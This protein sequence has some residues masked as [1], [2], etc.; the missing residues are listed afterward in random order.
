MAYPGGCE[1]YSPEWGMNLVEMC[2]LVACWVAL[3]P[4][5]DLSD[6]GTGVVGRT[7]TE[8]KKTMTTLD[9]TGGLMLSNKYIHK[10]AIPTGQGYK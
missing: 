7:E 8:G 6:T 9:N 3:V 2:G 5:R 10:A 4:T 1:C